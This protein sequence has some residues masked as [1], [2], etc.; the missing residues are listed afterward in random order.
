LSWRRI[1]VLHIACWPIWQAARVESRHSISLPND[2]FVCAAQ[3]G[4]LR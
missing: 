1:G 2:R 4:A 3:P